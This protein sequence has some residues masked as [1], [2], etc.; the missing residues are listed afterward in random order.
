MSGWGWIRA[1][2]FT[3]YDARRVALG[4]L[5]IVATGLK[6]HQLATEPILGRG[7]FNSRWFLLGVVEWELLF[8][9]WLLAG[10]WPRTTWVIALCCFGVFT[11]ISLYKAI[12]GEATCGCFGRLR[13]SPWFTLLLDISAIL[14]LLAFPPHATEPRRWAS[15]RRML[16]RCGITATLWLLAGV[17]A[18]I[19]MGNPRIATLDG[20]MSLPRDGRVVVLQPEAWVGKRFP[21]AAHI[22]VGGTLSQGEW[23]VVLYRH[24]CPDCRQALPRYQERAREQSIARRTSRL[25]LVQLPPYA[26][27]EVGLTSPDR[28][29]CLYGVLSDAAHWFAVTPIEVR[30]Q[31]G[32]VLGV[33]SGLG[34][35]PATSANSAPL[36]LP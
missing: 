28:S 33:R 5:L 7:I 21:L 29:A 4:L 32:V 27:H 15:R 12:S 3:A 2:R 36:R 18:A 20:G 19:A 16:A 25:A 34:T 6:A 22:D 24:D 8:G 17:P 23:T 1:R 13:V 35:S 11:A 30:L 14:A 10:L 26:E 9:L 31:E